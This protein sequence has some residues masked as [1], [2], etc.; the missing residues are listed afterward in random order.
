VARIAL[1]VIGLL[2]ILPLGLS[3]LGSVL[4]D[5]AMLVDAFGLWAVP[6]FLAVPVTVAVGGM[7]VSD[8]RY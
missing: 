4:S 6:I 1:Y 3:V 8:R 5:L 2:V 7:L